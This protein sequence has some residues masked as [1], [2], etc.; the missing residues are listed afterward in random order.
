VAP[1][2]L[3]LCGCLCSVSQDSQSKVSARRQ[4]ILLAKRLLNWRLRLGVRRGLLPV[5]PSPIE[6][7]SEHSSPSAWKDL[8]QVS[9]RKC[10]YIFPSLTTRPAQS[11]SNLLISSIQDN[12][13]CHAFHNILPRRCQ[14]ASPTRAFSLSPRLRQPH[15]DRRQILPRVGPPRL[16]PVEPSRRRRLEYHSS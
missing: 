13:L 7:T 16:L 11:H 6:Q 9:E 8:G 15:Q 10:F 1:R 2:R 5:E 12:N 14:R 3:I 4:V